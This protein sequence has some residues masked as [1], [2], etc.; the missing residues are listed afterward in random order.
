[1]G[2][3]FKIAELDPPNNYLLRVILP[4]DEYIIRLD[5]YNRQYGRERGASLEPIFPTRVNDVL[6]M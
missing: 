1:M 2:S 4:V 5:I 3:V 6:I